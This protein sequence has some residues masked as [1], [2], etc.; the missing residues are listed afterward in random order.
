MLFRSHSQGRFSY[1]ESSSGSGTDMA[2]DFWTKRSLRHKYFMQLQLEGQLRHEMLLYGL[3]GTPKSSGLFDLVGGTL[4]AANLTG[5]MNLAQSFESFDMPSLSTQQMAEKA[6]AKAK[7]A[8]MM[9]SGELTILGSSIAGVPF[10][11]V[12]TMTKQQVWGN[13]TNRTAL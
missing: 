10:D 5:L 13:E 7:L 9:N 12:I 11:S 2:L 8:A 1:S 3:T 6:E 4:S